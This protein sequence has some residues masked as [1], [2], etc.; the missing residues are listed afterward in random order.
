MK[1][2]LQLLSDISVASP[3]TANWDEMIGDDHARF[4]GQCEKNV[5][6]LSA[7]TAE[8]AMNLIREK[9]GKLCGRYFQR[10]DGTILT[11]DCPVGLHHRV[12]R[13]RRLAVLAASFAGLLSFSGCAK[14]DD[15]N[16]GT[17]A[18]PPAKLEK[19]LES[20]PPVQ[21]DDKR[22]V[23]GKVDIRGFAPP[24]VP[25]AGGAPEVLPAPR[26]FEATDE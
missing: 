26:G 4:C 25:P 7:L 3:C 1:T 20:S 11:A 8:A 15:P 24:A 17:T 2:A 9:E 16:T 6:N 5:Y 22:C 10:A 18:K 21:K 13:K 23:M 12:R 14:F 19:P